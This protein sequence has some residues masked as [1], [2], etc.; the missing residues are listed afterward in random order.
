DAQAQRSIKQ[1]RAA[2]L[3]KPSG[4]RALVANN[5]LAPDQER[6]ERWGA[7]LDQLR[8]RDQARNEQIAHQAHAPS[9]HINPI[10]L[11]RA[12][13]DAIDPSAIL[14]GDGGDFVATASYTIRP[15]G[16]LAW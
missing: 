11:C 4:L 13:E 6:A 1:D 2:Q 16:P 15:R 10:Q 5:P 7:W 9:A 8:A 14:I 12:I 3:L